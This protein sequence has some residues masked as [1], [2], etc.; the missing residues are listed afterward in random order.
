[1]KK[2]FL[3]RILGLV[4]LLTV[5][6]SCT[7]NL[8]FNQ[9]KTLEVKPNVVANL[10]TF[11]I[12]AA[13]LAGAGTPPL[14]TSVDFDVFRDT[15]FQKNLVKAVF[16]FEID[17]TTNSEFSIEIE[18]QTSNGARLYDFTIDVPANTTSPIVPKKHQ[19]IFENAGLNSLKST[20]KIVFRI[21]KGLSTGTTINPGSFKLRSSATAYLVIQ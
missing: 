3:N 10:A 20:E 9:A 8:D 11:E 5:S 12:T 18:L 2:D 15:F 16:D 19:E 7:S 6:S 4:F 17:N 21:T 1:M 13:Q 14:E